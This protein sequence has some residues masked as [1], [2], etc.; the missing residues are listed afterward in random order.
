MQL[1]FFGATEESAIREAAPPVLSAAGVWAPPE[2]LAFNA[3]LHRG[4]L[5]DALEILNRLKVSVATNVLLASGF[6][7]GK[8]KGR[9][10]LIAGVQMDV[11]AAARLRLTG[12]ELRAAREM[13]P[14]AVAVEVVA[15]APVVVDLPVDAESLGK[16]RAAAVVAE[17]QFKAFYDAATGK[18]PGDIEAE[19]YFALSGAMS[20]A[21]GALAKALGSLADDS[22]A[23]HGNTNDGRL[24]TLNASAQRAGHWQLTR[25]DAKGEPWGDTQ[26]ETKTQGIRDFLQD[27]D[28]KTL[29]NVD[30]LFGGAQLAVAP[31]IVPAL[32]QVVDA[33]VVPAAVSD[34]RS[35]QDAGEELTYNRRNRIKAAKGWGDIEHLNDALKVK[36]AVK[37]N[38]WPRPD[39]KQLL[40]D[41]IPPMV[42]HIV[43]QVY[44]SVAVKPVVG[45]KVLD[46]A[47]LQTYIAA[48]NRVE[49]GLMAWA[50]DSDAL[51]QWTAKN[52]KAAGAMLGRATPLSDLV[53]KGDKTL[54]GMVY[55]EGYKSYIDEIRMVGGNKMLGALQ[56]G[57]ADITRAMKAIDGGWPE[58]REAWEV[59]GYRV[60][61]DAK[62][63]FEKMHRGDGYFL[64]VNERYVKSFD[65]LEE[66]QAGVAA[67]KPV[68]LFGKR[69][70]V[71]SFDSEDAAIAA[72]KE[73][74]QK[75]R[76][77]GVSEK[78]ERVDA[79]ER[80]GVSRRMEG[81]DIS[82]ERL[83]TEFGFKG[84]NFGN[85]MKTP[86]ARDEAQLHL[87][88][89]FDSFHDL[90]D[91][92]GVPPKAMS[93]GGM[94][95]LA[96]GA[97]GGGGTAAAHFV[98]GVDE[99]NLTRT[100]GAGFLTHEY[101]HALDHYFAA[102]AGLA[103]ATEPYL[104]AHADLGET[105]T[106]F[107]MVDGRQ[108]GVKVPRFGDVRPEIVAAVKV[109]VNTM[110]RRMETED[111][112]KAGQVSSMT[113]AR[114]S[115]VRSLK[116]MRRDF[117]GQEAAFDAIGERVLAGDV[118]DGKVAL[119]SAL[120][121]SPVVVEIRDLYKASKG[122][123]YPV[124]NVKD[125]Q[126]SMN[127]MAY[128]ASKAAAEVAHVPQQVAS[129][130]A[131]NAR[132][133]DREKGGKPYW[134]TTLEKFARAF[135]AFV[136][137]ELEAKQAKNSYLSRTG[138]AD[139]TVPAGAEREAINA[140]FR[141]LVGEFKVRETEKGPVLFSVGEQ[142]DKRSEKT[143]SPHFRNWFGNSKVIGAD[144]KPLVVY[145]GTVVKSDFAEFNASDFFGSGTFGKGVN[146]T[147]SADDA[148]KYASDEIGVNHDL[149]PKAEILA[150]EMTGENGGERFSKAYQEAKE[151]LR[152]GN[153]QVIPAF[154]SMQNPL[155][156]SSQKIGVQERVFVL[157]AIEADLSRDDADRL[158][159]AWGKAKD[160]VEQFEITTRFNANTIYR[161]IASILNKDGL[162]I[163]PELAPR[164]NGGTHYLVFDSTQIKSA[165]GN[166]LEF[167][168]KN[169]DIRFSIED[170][171]RGGLSLNDVNK[172][173]SGL[174]S[175]WP[176]MPPVIV[177]KG[178][179]DLP[180]EAPWN[181]DG[182]YSEGKVYVVADNIA[183]LKQLQKVMAHECVLHH[184]LEDMLG[185]Y[186]FAKLHR[187]IQK[188]KDA[189]DPV[190]GKLA[191]NIRG[192]YGELP[193]EIE[194]KEIVAR[195]GEQCLDD[196]G[197]IKV[198]FGFMKGVFAGIAGWLRDHGIGVPFTNLELQGIMH[199]A[200][201][202]VKQG[203][204]QEQGQVQRP[205]R[206]ADGVDGAVVL[207]SFAGGRP[208]VADGIHSGRVIDVAGGVVTQ[209]TGR[210]DDEIVLH[211][212]ERLSDAVKIGDVVDIKYVGGEGQVNGP[213]VGVG[214]GR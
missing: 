169:P 13:V 130:Y 5:V 74:G 149:G 118:G 66:A 36:E 167:D 192:R 195:A 31:V 76:A 97:Q 188:L 78:G 128:R 182:A 53:G 68:I 30:G 156:L 62:V 61:Q 173:I 57:Y 171:G 58:K 138:V 160:G 174:R 199:N 178:V 193:P 80:E 15:V 28:S 170:H 123:A 23:L 102:Q 40:A 126:S 34:L 197:E 95:G 133:L 82:S 39:Y 109:I 107:K 164:S 100:N 205:A 81:E 2:T 207:N 176:G 9:A 180:F 32:N 89:A 155:V 190:V 22:F 94:L 35:I 84:V 172:E 154:L 8:G 119:S 141:G 158:Y 98:P 140:A 16:L 194:T 129:D 59:Q 143:D 139:L 113:W 6:A 179:A 137:D 71:D 165:I 202:W 103:S 60:V 38:V 120:Y 49:A 206:G 201:E 144:G 43:K 99:I 51:Q 26:Y 135:D 17:D 52:A 21:Q 41:G 88:H 50:T 7:L 152:G 42:A 65:S 90:A 146:F 75:Q 198:S 14:V 24:V 150:R 56:P 159:R 79:V 46:D 55:P 191:E 203:P 96:F 127:S 136:S 86:S 142:L 147:S 92:L 111:E 124:A 132:S 175:R 183:D 212:M 131:K 33:S 161:Q 114:D 125:L 210:A 47:A 151:L 19:Q 214:R 101:A 87:N 10:E 72:A 11:L 153:G 162:I 104:S 163:K 91:I 108:T 93:L 44:D 196:K 157:A 189:G 70:F 37:A 67:V 27:I 134:S 69:G 204:V 77:Q 200:G 185:D 121:V 48:L 186:G 3:A 106:V 12:S 187:G 64:S 211:S 116:T 184:G 4:S 25:F 168:P 20:D 105:Q 115:L 208:L 54:L 166:N 213:A 177:V 45:R 18:N 148:N 73:R 122:R 209:K 110:D 1:D 145:H 63:E 117:I 181:A 85:W 112:V 83:M 29:D